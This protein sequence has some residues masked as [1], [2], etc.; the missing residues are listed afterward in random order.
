ML[1]SVE[2]MLTSRLVGDNVTAAC[3]TMYALL[4]AKRYTPGDISSGLFSAIFVQA[5]HLLITPVMG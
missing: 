1:A 2:T 4:V 5:R 3:L